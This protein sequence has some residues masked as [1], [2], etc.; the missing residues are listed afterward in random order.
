MT[1]APVLCAIGR[2][3]GVPA[4]AAWAAQMARSIDASL[5][6]VH[7]VQPP[8]ITSAA[9]PGAGAAVAAADPGVIEEVRT[10]A[11]QRLRGICELL[12]PECARVRVVEGGS[13]VE[14]LREMAALETASMI[15]LGTAGHGLL[16]AAL[17]GSPS[18]ALLAEL[19][20]PLVAVPIGDEER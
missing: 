3:K 16:H 6:L 18:H 15:V 2:E 14:E 4:Q 1:R 7:V 11:E 8:L 20:C 13:V 12:A 5:V 10:E 17:V 9:W 19:P